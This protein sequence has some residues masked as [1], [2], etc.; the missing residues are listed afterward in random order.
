MTMD[1]YHS[2]R[3]LASARDDLAECRRYVA[4]EPSLSAPLISRAVSILGVHALLGSGLY[5]YDWKIGRIRENL[6][7]AM[8]CLSVDPDVT[9]GYVV[10][11]IH[12][13]G[14]IASELRREAEAGARDAELAGAYGPGVS[15]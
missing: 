4:S 11:A 3:I 6:K 7:V 13:L 12:E 14:S 9:L 10:G 5:R 8:R 1:G 15:P 2:I